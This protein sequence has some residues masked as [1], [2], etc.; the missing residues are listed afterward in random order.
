MEINAKELTCDWIKTFAASENLDLYHMTLVY[1]FFQNG[2]FHA[3]NINAFFATFYMRRFL[4]FL[5]STKN[6]HTN[7][8]RTRQPTTC[9]FV[10]DHLN[11]NSEKDHIYSGKLFNHA[12]VCVPN[13]IKDKTCALLGVDTLTKEFSIPKI[14]NI[15]YS[16]FK[17]CDDVA[18]EIATRSIFKYPNY[19]IFSPKVKFK[20]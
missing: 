19:Q 3:D 6:Y 15:K 7:F 1:D 17:K 20:K 8:Q 14:Y 18:I 2:N 11:K 5:L 12:I 4:P 16:T 13:V 10:C 9:A